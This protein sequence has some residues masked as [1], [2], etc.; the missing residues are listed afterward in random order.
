MVDKNGK[1]VVMLDEVV[2]KA[3]PLS[4]D[5]FGLEPKKAL[6][7]SLLQGTDE[8]CRVQLV[9]LAELEL[10]HEG[11]ALFVKEGMSA[12]EHQ[13]FT[14]MAAHNVNRS[15]LA[16]VGKEFTFPVSEDGLEILQPPDLGS[17]EFFLG[18][19]EQVP[20]GKKGRIFAFLALNKTE[21]APTDFR[22]EHWATINELGSFLAWMFAQKGFIDHLSLADE[23][24][25]A[26][27]ARWLRRHIKY[28]ELL[29]LEERLGPVTFVFMDVDGFKDVNDE[30]GHVF[31]DMAVGHLYDRLRR[32]FKKTDSI[33]RYGKGDEFVIV[34]LD[35][36]AKDLARRFRGSNE[37]KGLL[38]KAAEDWEFKQGDQSID[39]FELSIGIAELKKE[40]GNLIE[41][42]RRA[43]YLQ[44]LVKQTG[45]LAVL[46]DCDT[47][48]IA[49]REEDIQKAKKSQKKGKSKEK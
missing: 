34:C 47:E 22:A 32:H 16:D 23:K 3:Q 40:D 37:E 44:G 21:T 29:R 7:S 39:G 42:L 2:R 35:A 6:I 12:G 25:G 46:A 43:D 13:Q 8:F 28:L 27:N 14:L 20:A 1:V 45:K 49:R 33:V 41:V 38:F 26:W 24:T 10:H 4:G 9:N 48:D 36:G 19:R 11:L 5:P 30:K 31:A 15:T 18:F 17:W